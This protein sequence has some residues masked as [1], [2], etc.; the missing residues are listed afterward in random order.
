DVEFAAPA[1]A[2]STGVGCANRG[3]DLAHHVLKQ[4]HV[5]ALG[6]GEHGLGVVAA[7]AVVEAEDGVEVDGP[8][9][10]VLRHLEVVEPGDA[11]AGLPGESDGPGDAPAAVL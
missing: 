3:D 4:R 8:P 1:D 5:E 6:R 10:L 11:V 2:T 7:G 9:Q